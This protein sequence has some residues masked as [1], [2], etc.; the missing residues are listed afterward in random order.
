MCEHINITYGD[1]D[2]RGVCDD[3]GAACDWHYERD[4]VEVFGA[5]KEVYERVPDE[6]HEKEDMICPKCKRKELLTID[7]KQSYN[8]KEKYED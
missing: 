7:D 3:C 1:D 5:T 4:E 2:E 6:W 8:R